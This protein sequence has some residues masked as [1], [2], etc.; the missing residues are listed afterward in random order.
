MGDD[1]WLEEAIAAGHSRAVA[2]GA[3]IK[4]DFPNM[5]SAA[6]IFES[7]EGNGVIVGAFPEQCFSACAYRGELMGLMAIHLI[8]LAANKV[9]PGLKG[10]IDIHCDCLG[11]MEKVAGLPANRIPTKCSHSD[12]LK[13]IMVNCRQLTCEIEYL[14]VRAHQDDDVSYHLLSRPSQLNCIVDIKAKR[15]IWGLEGKPLPAQQVFPLGPV[16]QSL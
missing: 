2:D 13:N 5:F 9:R 1:D 15:V 3:Y 11:G 7:T 16:W 8:L 6:F 10:K 4:E 14:H 12:I